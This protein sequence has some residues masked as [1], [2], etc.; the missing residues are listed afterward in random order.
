MVERGDWVP[1][2]LSNRAPRGTLDLTPFLA[3][4]Q[5]YRVLDGGPARTA[6]TCSCVG[7]QAVFFGGAMLRYR[8]ADFAPPAM[9]VGDAGAEWPFRYIDLEPYYG[10]VEQLLDVAGAGDQP[11][12]L[13]GAL[14]IRSARHR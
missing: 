2:D 3:A 11:A 10:A 6:R 1:R 8:E 14:H 5:S 12:S 4:D 7:G 9:I 13:L